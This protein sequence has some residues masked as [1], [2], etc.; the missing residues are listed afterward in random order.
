MV[1]LKSGVK[2]RPNVT[3]K[4]KSSPTLPP[5]VYPKNKSKHV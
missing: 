3:I 2:A 1:K 5:K 4:S